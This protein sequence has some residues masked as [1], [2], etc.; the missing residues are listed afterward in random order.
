[1]VGRALS[2]RLNLSLASLL[3][4]GAGLVIGVAA[5]L[6]PGALLE[7]LVMDSGIPALFPAAEPPLGITARA[8]I[9]CITGGGTALFGW[10]G[11][12][13]LLDGKSFGATRADAAIPSV[14]RAD[15]HPDAPPRPPVHAMRDLGVPF[16]DV[17]ADQPVAAQDDPDAVRHESAEAGSPPQASAPVLSQ[18]ER[19]AID[20]PP[21]AAPSA[22]AIADEPPAPRG[23]PVDLDMPLSAYDPWAVPAEPL[24][25]PEKVKPLSRPERPAIFGPNERIETFELTPPVRPAAAPAMREHLSLVAT[26]SPIESEPPMSNAARAPSQP[27]IPPIPAPE[28]ARVPAPEPEATRPLAGPATDMSIHALLERLERGVARRAETGPG[29]ATPERVPEPAPKQDAHNLNDTLAAL[30]ELAV[31]A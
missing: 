5:F 31:R 1:M 7:S 19:S 10:F 2:Q 28:P 26:A 13:L 12:F 8:A 14:R 9:A 23:L 27:D 11:L 3:G 25:A 4:G 21:P 20:A 24:P 18:P 30:R 17:H 15:A 16:L 22:P 29:P 6:L